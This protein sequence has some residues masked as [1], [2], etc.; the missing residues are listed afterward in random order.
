MSVGHVA[1]SLRTSAWAQRG[2]SE[3]AHRLHMSRRQR[4]LDE[5]RA[6]CRSGAVARALDLAFEHFAQFGRD[7]EIVDLLGTAIDASDVPERVRRR[8][9]DLLPPHG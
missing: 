7:D 1:S 8:L 5:L 2:V 3:P 6:L 4:Q 9:T